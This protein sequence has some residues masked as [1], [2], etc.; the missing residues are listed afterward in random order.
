MMKA[1]LLTV[2]ALTVSVMALDGGMNK[3]NAEAGFNKTSIYVVAEN[4][5]GG[6]V[7]NWDARIDKI[8][9]RKENHREHIE[10]AREK[11]QDHMENVQERREDHKERMENMQERRDDHHDK[12]EAFREHREERHEKFKDRAENFRDKRPERTGE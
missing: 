6:K 1:Q 10:D 5:R 12:M 7:S 8:K 4:Q 3:V 11:R 9:E 2:L